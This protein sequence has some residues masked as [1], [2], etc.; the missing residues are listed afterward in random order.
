[1][2]P[3]FNKRDADNHTF[4][5]GIISIDG[6]DI[7]D[8]NP[9]WLRSHIGTV[10]Q[11]TNSSFTSQHVSLQT[12]KVGRLNR[13]NRSLRVQII[14]PS[15]PTP[16]SQEPVLFSCSIRDNIAYGAVDPDAVTTEDI[17]RAARVA[18]AYNFIQTFPKGFDTVVGEKG[19]LLSGET[20]RQRH[21]T[22]VS[23]TG[24]HLSLGISANSFP[25]VAL[26]LEILI[27]N[28]PHHISSS[29]NS[30]RH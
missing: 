4:S 21:N 23:T 12:S 7:R 29:L 27:S 9:Y 11:V 30:I 1:M 20:P 16:F 24:K 25:Q 15:P 6:H 5:P 13:N 26:H 22:S 10:S 3:N 2:M 19:V 8:L 14:T 18:N 17:Y 28:V